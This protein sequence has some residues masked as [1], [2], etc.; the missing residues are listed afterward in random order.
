MTL[1]DQATALAEYLLKEAED[2]SLANVFGKWLHQKI[3]AF[4]ETQGQTECKG[5]QGNI[6]VLRIDTYDGDKNYQEEINF[7]CPL[8][9]DPEEY[10]SAHAS[11]EFG[12]MKNVLTYGI[13]TEPGSQTFRFPGDE[14]TVTVLSVQPAPAD[15]E[16]DDYEVVFAES[17]A[18]YRTITGKR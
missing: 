4:K 17:L 3:D 15:V 8:G 14:R 13:P 10:G 1:N 12:E 7:F 6:Y 5:V 16:S 11:A 2:L 9:E 18:H